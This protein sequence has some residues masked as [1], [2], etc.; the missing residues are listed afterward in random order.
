MAAAKP[1]SAT[2]GPTAY[3]VILGG[4]ILAMLVAKPF[5][6]SMEDRSRQAECLTNL[7][8]IADSIDERG[9][10]PCGP[11]PETPP[12][13]QPV[14]WSVMPSCFLAIGF[15]PELRLWG[16]YA[17]LPRGEGG[18]MATCALDLDGDGDSL[19]YEATDERTAARR[20]G[21]ED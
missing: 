14:D 8:F 11:W 19:V 7:E 5:L 21:T 12:S 10:I 4:F 16:S 15:D 6:G 3:L 13:E 18:W 17:V 1:S 9:L 2:S 20:E